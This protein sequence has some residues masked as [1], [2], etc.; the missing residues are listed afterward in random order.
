M[1]FSNVSLSSFSIDQNSSI[2]FW[3]SV[4]LGVVALT[5]VTKV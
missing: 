4:A 5:L 1:S 3:G 2:P